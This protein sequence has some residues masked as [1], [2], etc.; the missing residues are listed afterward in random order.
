MLQ[1]WIFFCL[2]FRLIV[3]LAAVVLLVGG[4]VAVREAPWD[5]FPE[6]AP[7]QIVVQTEA[8]GLS[9]EEVERLVTIPIESDLNGVSRI[10]TLR[11]SSAP[12]LSVVTTIFEDD[13][14]ILDAR[15]LVAERLTEIA[16][17][18]PQ[19]VEP[20]RMTPLA[21]STSRLA[22]IGLSSDTVSLMELRTMADWTSSRRIRAVRGVAHVEVFGGDVKQYQ[23]F[24]RPNRLQK[25]QVSLE[26]IVAASRN[27]TGFGGAGYVETP[28]Q[29]LPIR[30]RTQLAS[31]S[32]IAAVPVTVDDGVPITLGQ[33]ADVVVGPA[34][35]PGG[36]TINGKR[37]VLLIVH[38][39]TFFNTLSVSHAVEHALCHSRIKK[40]INFV[41]ICQIRL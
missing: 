28:N 40:W 1:R 19:S 11:S 10:K 5:V 18:L 36:A 38:K 29:R 15:Q 31:V 21:A 17:Q 35:K 25:Y 33:L 2:R 39:Q 12:E 6:F 41:I 27:A 22:M 34:D 23:I 13:T 26:Q 4:G 9:S 20:P 30:Q 7:P 37:G 32:D 8:P 16:S 3:M 24:V 14:D